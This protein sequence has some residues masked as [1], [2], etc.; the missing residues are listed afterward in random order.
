MLASVSCSAGSV[1][2]PDCQY[3]VAKVRVERNTLPATA[4]RPWQSVMIQTGRAK[5]VTSRKWRGAVWGAIAM[6]TGVLFSLPVRLASVMLL[7]MTPRGRPRELAR[8]A[9]LRV[10][11]TP[12]LMDWLRR[13]AHRNVRSMSGELTALLMAAREA[14]DAEK[15]LA[16]GVGG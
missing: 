12:D 6:L 16:E 14:A 11:V 2:H 9:E 13:R 3:A 7:R 1:R 8:T 15:R 5:R 4:L 10:Y